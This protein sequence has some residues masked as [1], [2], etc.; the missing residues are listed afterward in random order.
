MA[1]AASRLHLGPA[2]AAGSTTDDAD[3]NV[4]GS[5]TCYGSNAS[6][7]ESPVEALQ[8][9]DLGEDCLHFLAY[10]LWYGVCCSVNCA[11]L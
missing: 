10:W 2:V 3:P 11:H 1:A 4:V 9:G 7:G 8:S 5:F 6:H